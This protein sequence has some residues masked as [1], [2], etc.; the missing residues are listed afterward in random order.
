M[1][2][3]S[4]IFRNRAMTRKESLHEGTH[5]KWFNLRI[6]PRHAR[7]ISTNIKLR[8]KPKRRQCSERINMK[9][10]RKKSLSRSDNVVNVQSRS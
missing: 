10:F 7:D 6:T 5:Q 9:P 2:K 8:K 3:T 4:K 1:T